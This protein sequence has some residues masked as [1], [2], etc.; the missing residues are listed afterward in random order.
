[1]D[2]RKLTEGLQQAFFS[3]NHRLVLWYDP[4]QTFEDELSSLEL[5]DVQVLRMD[6]EVALDVKIRLELEDT[7]SKYLLYFPYSELEPE[8]DWL[9]D[10]KLYSRVFYADRI[11]LI[12][13]DL[14]LQKHSL[15]AHLAQHQGFLTKGRVESLKRHVQPDFEEEELDLAMVAV[16]ARAQSPDIATIV[17]T[18]ADQLAEL[19]EGLEAELDVF[20]EIEKFALTS[21][22]VRAL[23][24]E[25]GYPASQ[26]ELSGEAGF[27]FGRF[28][29]C[30][31]ATGFC[32]S[33]SDIPD[34]ARSVAMPSTSA[35]ATSRALLS[36]WRDSSRFYAAYDVISDWVSQALD[37]KSRIAE[38]PMDTLA[39]VATFHDV[40]ERLI[41]DLAKEIP[42]VR[43]A[44]LAMFE[45]IIAERLDGYWA[46]RHKNDKTRQRYRT[47]YAALSSAI[48]LFSLRHEYDDGFHYKSSESLYKAYEEDLYRF[49]AAYRHYCSASQEAAVELLKSLDDAVEQCYSNW[50][51]GQL[52]RNWGELIESED[53][54]SHWQISGV[55]KQQDFYDRWVRKTVESGRSRRLVV[56]ISDAF[57]YEAA[58]ELKERINEKRYS[59]AELASQLGVLPSYTTLGMAALLPH[60]TLEYRE[61][62]SGDVL[63]D[64]KST[65]GSDNRN[66]ILGGYEGMAVKAETV[67][68]WSRD[69]G[70]EALKDQHLVYVFHNVVDARGDSSSTESETFSAVERAIDE[71]TELTRKFLMHFNTASVLVTADHGFLFQHSHPEGAD[72]TGLV[73]KP[74]NAIKSKKRYVIGHELPESDSV[75]HGS[76]RQTAGTQSDTQFWIPKGINRFHFVGGARFVHGGAMPQEVVVPVLT[77]Q[78]LRGEKAERRTKRKVEVI[79][80]KPSLRMVNNIQRFDLMQTEPVTDQVMPI[81]LA[82][83]I[84]DGDVIVSSEE[85]VT[86]DSDSDSMSERVKQVRLSLSGTDF[87]RK[88]EYALVLKDKGTGVECGRYRV[89]IDLAFTD[90][91]F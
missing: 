23:Q 5:P 55:P 43:S 84:Y 49:D 9:L 19:G 48:A 79:S 14:N 77:V 30:L 67:R 39:G 26:E 80:S 16:L 66:K 51:L 91:F 29:I 69:E 25:V 70:R 71:L 44:D 83:G 41:V 50:Y 21:A 4:E 54:L 60:K 11:S 27:N 1:M 81:T 13:N 38:L 56:I 85:V 57:R 46:S 86:F 82:V 34:W 59:Q 74:N 8:Q 20:R 64:G 62:G 17:F 89:V 68:G 10:I 15:R 42:V 52:S 72:R 22:L 45:R 3:E 53:R 18:L 63:V 78:Q 35:R 73:E 90:D 32:E 87:D 37:I 47:M 40:E 65:Q 28:L 75:W 24:R 6:K 7:E 33:I 58:A 88:K 61:D 36:R 2:S 31:L 76:T 12:F